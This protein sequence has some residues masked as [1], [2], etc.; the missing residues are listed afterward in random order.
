MHWGLYYN[1]RPQPDATSTSSRAP[2]TS[3]AA[4]TRS[5]PRAGSRP[6]SASRTG[7]IPREAVLR[8]VPLLPGHLR[9]VAGRRRARSATRARTTGA[10]PTTARCEYAGMRV[11]PSWGGSMFEALMPSL[12][13]PEEEWGP[14]SWGANHPL[15]V[16]AQIHHGMEEAGY[17]YWGFSPSANP[18]GGYSVYGVDGIGSDPNG[19]PSN[20]PP[21]ADRP[22][23]AR[24][25]R[26]PGAAR[27]AAVGL[28]ERRRHAARGL[29]RAAVL[30]RRGAG[31]PRPARARLPRALRRARVPRRGQRRHGHDIRLL[32]VARPGHGDGGSRQRA[33]RR[34]AA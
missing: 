19:Y 2:A 27:S 1:A 3:P 8:A 5:S 20:N 29:P 4:T 14:G 24:L 7:E 17:G 22:R 28:H 30:A 9:L 26:P 32:P 16:A 18:E 33:H 34:R 25:P 13:L 23:L 11:T 12:F 10:R 21:H 31:Q 15:T 6:T